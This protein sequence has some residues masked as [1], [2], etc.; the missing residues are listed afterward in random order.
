MARAVE[1]CKEWHRNIHIMPFAEDMRHYA[2][3]QK[4]MADDTLLI[5]L[6][7]NFQEADGSVTIPAV[8]RPY[9]GGRERL[10]PKR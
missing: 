8:L 5:P 9:M 10:V 7:E 1:V 6:L 3:V 2:E 4:K